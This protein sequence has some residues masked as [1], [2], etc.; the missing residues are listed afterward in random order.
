MV[1]DLGLDRVVVYKL[2]AETAELKQHA[3]IVVP[4][5]SGPRHMKFHTTGKYVYVLNE[6][7]LTVSVFEFDA[8]NA[9]FKNIQL[10]ETLPDDEK[11]KHLNSAAEI[12][13]HPTGRFVYTSNR[14]H[15]SITVFSVDQKTGKLMLVEREPIRGSVPRNFNIDP[16]GKWLIAAGQSS[17]TLALFEIDLASGQLIFT[18]KVVNVPAPIC[19]LFG[20]E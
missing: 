13:V 15:D 10:I 6:L 9:T 1:P 7:T 3:K 14:G 16:S 19:V 5:G 12:R 8:T 4:P 17:N 20:P 2:N 18:R 11:D